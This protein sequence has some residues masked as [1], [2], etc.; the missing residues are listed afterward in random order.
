M[1]R[2]S[3]FRASPSAP[4]E[5]S[6]PLG[7]PLS[8]ETVLLRKSHFAEVQKESK[9]D[10]LSAIAAGRAI[11]YKTKFTVVV[12]LSFGSSDLLAQLSTTT[13]VYSLL[14]TYCNS[15]H[16]LRLQDLYIPGIILPKTTEI[17]GLY[18]F[19]WT[20]CTRKQDP[21]NLSP[22]LPLSSFGSNLRRSPS[23]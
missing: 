2:I 14:S 21:T 22:C 11:Q 17:K 13:F 20:L 9:Q 18:R 3:H 16:G 8:T 4:S 1:L 5:L 23:K 19:L 6:Q 15:S 7:R 10:L 12:L